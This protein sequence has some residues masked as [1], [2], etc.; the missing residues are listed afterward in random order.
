MPQQVRRRRIFSRL[1]RKAAAILSRVRPGPR[2]LA[3]KARG[4]GRVISPAYT[5]PTTAGARYPMPEM[6]SPSPLAALLDHL[7][8]NAVR[9]DGPF[10]LRSGATSDWYIDARRTTFSG[11]G[12][13]LV[14][15]AVYDLLRPEVRTVGGMTMGADPIA[16]ATAVYAAG[17]GSELRAFSVRKREKEHGLAGRLAG[18]VEEGDTAAI[19]EDTVT[20]GGAMAEAV[21]AAWEAGL[22]VMQIVVLVDRSAGAAEDRAAEWGIP[23][24]A[25][26]SPADL[27]V[28]P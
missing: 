14:G 15:E 25:L 26:A 22:E 20:T 1:L 6:D 12:A 16:V 28:G 11:Y 18:P 13:R 3:K 4:D 2:Q 9:T 7:R 5:R 8:Q 23:Y 21:Q 27:G 19:V 24:Q 17:R 10:T